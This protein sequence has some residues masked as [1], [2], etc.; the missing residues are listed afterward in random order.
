MFVLETKRVHPDSGRGQRIKTV[1]LRYLQRTRPAADLAEF[2]PV[3]GSKVMRVWIVDGESA[4][5]ACQDAVSH[6]SARVEDQRVDGAAPMESA[7]VK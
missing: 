5:R 3:L 4:R 1:S 2:A 6:N 7:Y